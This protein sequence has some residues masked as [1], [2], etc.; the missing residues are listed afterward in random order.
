M[1]AVGFLEV[2]GICHSIFLF[3]PFLW[4]FFYSFQAK[5]GCILTNLE[6]SEGIV[7]LEKKF[8]FSA[9]PAAAAVVAAM[10]L[11]NICGPWSTTMIKDEA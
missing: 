10:S 9:V 2:F 3:Q 5:E 4:D 1:Y 8:Y 7:E 6:L 11:E